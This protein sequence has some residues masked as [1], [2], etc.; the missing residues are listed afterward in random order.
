MEEGAEPSWLRVPLFGDTNVIR[1]Y[2][3]KSFDHTWL[4]K[5]VENF[6]AFLLGS[7]D[8]V[9]F[10]EADEI[11]TPNP[12]K[13]WDGSLTAWLDDWYQ[14]GEP[15][16]RCTGYEVIHKL[17]D[18]PD[19]DLDEVRASRGRVLK[20]RGW[21]Y[22]SRLYSKILTWR[23]PPRWCNG[24]HEAYRPMTPDGGSMPMD[25]LEDP[26]L[27]LLHLHRVDWR[28]AVMRW[29]ATRARDWNERDLKH[30]QAGMQN[31]FENEG[32]LR[33]WW[34][35]NIDDVSAQAPLVAMP[36]DIKG[37]V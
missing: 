24:F 14:K 8:T 23:V 1:V 5:Q 28:V 19:L 30:P 12:Y 31:R 4:R 34:Y 7:Y 11:I 18:E 22:P 9:T 37:I 6:A 33:H 25:L 20:D 3:D 26:Q 27:L 29:R 15:A 21:W 17:G 32:Q 13:V 16:A 10:A 2:R 35:K 36:D